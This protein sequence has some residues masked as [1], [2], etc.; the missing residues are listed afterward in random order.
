MSGIMAMLLSPFVGYVKE[1]IADNI[2]QYRVVCKKYSSYTF[3]FEC[4]HRDDPHII[5]EKEGMYLLGHRANTWNS[6]VSSD[7]TSLDMF[8]DQFGAHRVESFNMRVDDLIKLSK[9]VLHEGFVFYTP[10]GVSAKIKSPFYLTAKWMARNPRTDKL[11]T[12]EFKEQIDEEYYGLL[13]YIRENI[14]SF[15]L[16]TEQARLQ[17]IRDYLSK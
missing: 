1:L 3:M 17:F 14:D 11:L 7:P 12:K 5:P 13:T 10:Q 8:A 15:T 9:T 4:V 16:L 6:V 2:D